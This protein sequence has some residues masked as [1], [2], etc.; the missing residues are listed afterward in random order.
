MP[1][2]RQGFAGSKVAATGWRARA[3]GASVHL[4]LDGGRRVPHGGQRRASSVGAREPE[5]PIVGTSG[6][7]RTRRGRD[8]LEG[9]A[10]TASLWQSWRGRGGARSRAL[11]TAGRALPGA[12]QHTGEVV[13]REDEKKRGCGGPSLPKRT[14]RL[15]T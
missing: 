12:G 6:N 15:V 7:V 2:A 14:C 3:A 9:D 8:L 1:G 5:Y 4:D 10:R 11:G 13:A